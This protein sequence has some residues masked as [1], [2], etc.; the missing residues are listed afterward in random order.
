MILTIG[1]PM[2]LLVADEVKPLEDVEHFVRY[3]C[4]AE[5]NFAVGMARLEH[6]IAYVSKIGQDPF[7]KH[8]NKFLLAN[9]IDNRYVTF[10]DQLM[11][12]FQLKAKVKTG[13]PEVVNFR[14]NTAFANLEE[15]DLEVIDWQEIKHLHLTGIP[16][17]L[18]KSCRNAIYKLIETAKNHHVQISFD[19][20]LRLALWEDKAEMV[21]VINDIA[22]KA[23]IVLPGIGEG[24]I[25]T[26]YDK[27]EEIAEFYLNN[28][29]K[30]VIIKTGAKGAFV[31]TKLEEF[32]V[33]AFSVEKV[34]DTVG[35]GD[36]FAVGV[37]SAMLEGLQLFEAVKRGAAIG[38]LAIMSQGDNEG[39]PTRAGLAEFMKEKY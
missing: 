6:K 5:V 38:A 14:K 17:A 39:L 24:K 28:G 36:G 32:T 9:N 16:P 15:A 10:S 20:N 31:K 11:T 18:S 13:D 37:I 12:G 19:T 2:G 3:V 26:G 34:V 33:P 1:E 22:S 21:R 4:G 25:L 8:I 29:A 27:P 23:D 30:I 35:A 7:G